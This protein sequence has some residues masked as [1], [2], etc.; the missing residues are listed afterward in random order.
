MRPIGKANPDLKAHSQSLTAWRQAF[1]D[2]S[3]IPPRL[4]IQ[5]CQMEAPTDPALKSSFQNPPGPAGYFE[6]PK[7]P[8]PASTPP[9]RQAG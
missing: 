9:S 6:R 5:L 8:R 3:G 2:G 7:Q 4:N 1:P